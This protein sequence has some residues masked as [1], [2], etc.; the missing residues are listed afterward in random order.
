MNTNINNKK[1]DVRNG[2]PTSNGVKRF[3]LTKEGLIGLPAPRMLSGLWQAGLVLVLIVLMPAIILGDGEVTQKTTQEYPD[4][5]IKEI[6]YYQDGKKIAKKLFDE[7]G[8][9]TIEGKI[10]E[11]IAK[12]Y[13]ASGKLEDEATYKDGKQEGI[14]KIYYESGKL[15]IEGN[16]KNDKL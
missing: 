16:Y 11:G 8:N 14:H 2:R 15:E 1:T 13:Y 4:G 3:I 5:T 7:K 9:S 6:I 10:P 12:D